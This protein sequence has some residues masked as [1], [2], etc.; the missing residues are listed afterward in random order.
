MRFVPGRVVTLKSMH[1]LPGI[2]TP[3]LPSTYSPSVFSRKKIQSMPASGT[4]TGRT[5]AYRSS[6]RRR[7]TLA[8]SMVPPLG[9]SVGPFS[10]T[11]QV[12]TALSTSLGTASP[13]ASR[14][15]MVSPSMGFNTMLPAAISSFSKA[16]STRV[17]CLEMI[18]PMPSPSITPTVT[19]GRAVKSLAGA[20]FSMRPVRASCSSRRVLNWATAV[21]IYSFID[22]TSTLLNQA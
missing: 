3:R 10:S 6:S 8:D 4:A 12:L 20:A 1:S 11:S 22:I 16:S 21:S 14:F 7:V 17:L 9:V 15:S 2:S 5:L 13:F 18:G 19:T